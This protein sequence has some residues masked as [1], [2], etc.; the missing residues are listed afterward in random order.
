MATTKNV[1]FRRQNF[2]T[3]KP[4]KKAVYGN[5]RSPQERSYSIFSQESGRYLQIEQFE[6][7]ISS[8]QSTRFF[9]I[10]SAIETIRSALADYQ[11]DLSMER[12]LKAIQPA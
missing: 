1:R 9:Q 11:Q 2:G 6:E 8:L 7:W 5:S 3:V 10:R 12:L 4:F